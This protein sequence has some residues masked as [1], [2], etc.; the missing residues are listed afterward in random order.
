MFAASGYSGQSALL[1]FGYSAERCP[2]QNL[3]IWFRWIPNLCMLDDRK[4][5]ARANV[6]DFQ[7]IAILSPD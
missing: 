3:N 4:A 5:R 6:L 1:G 2:H 7:L